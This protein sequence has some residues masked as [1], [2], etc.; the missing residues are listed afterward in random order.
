MQQQL[1]KVME[2]ADG[3][4]E[5][6]EKQENPW[7]NLFKQNRLASH[8]MPLKYIPPSI[9]DGEIVVELDKAEVEKENAKW[10][11]AL[12]AYV[13][14]EVLGY[15]YMRRY[16]DR[17]WV[18]VTEPEL[19]LHE[20]GYYVVKFQDIGDMK[21]VLCS[22]PHTINNKPIILKQWSAHLDFE[23]EFL[24]EIPLWVTFPN[25]P[26]SCW[27]SDSLSRVAS[28]VGH[29]TFADECTTKQT[30]I[31]FAYMLIEVN[32]TKPLP[33]ME[34][35]IDPNGIKFQQDVAFDWKPEY[36]G[37]CLKI[38]HECP[39]PCAPPPPNEQPNPAAQPE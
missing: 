16:I 2:E 29:L 8:G 4:M 35:V 23:A 32:V 3:Y 1:D 20:K 24:T 11:C 25:L 9:V 5:S 31:S 30:R 18:D 12:I 21:K 6:L 10:R 19:F 13:I 7:V 26:M 36:Y 34:N 38:G 27:G 39:P 28:A 17:T 33:A 15:K 22:G 14:G 37:Q